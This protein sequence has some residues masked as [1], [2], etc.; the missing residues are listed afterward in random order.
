MRILPRVN[1]DVNEEWI[2]D[3]TRHVVDGLRTQRLDRPYIR[4]N[5]KLRP[6]SWPRPSRDRR[7]GEGR[8]AGERIGASPAILRVEEMF[9]LKELMARLGSPISIAARTARARSA[10]GRASYSSTDHRRHRAGRR[11]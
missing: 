7:Q 10:L 11:S 3:K 5:G 8:I 4:E 2:S 6:G 1:E 9:A